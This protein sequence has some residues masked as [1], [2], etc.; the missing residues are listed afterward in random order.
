MVVERGDY[1]GVHVGRA[2]I[3]ESGCFDVAT[4]FGNRITISWGDF[5]CC[6][7]LPAAV[8]NVAAQRQAFE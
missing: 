6:N 3:G 2:V 7:V 5:D 8:A 4:G 1:R